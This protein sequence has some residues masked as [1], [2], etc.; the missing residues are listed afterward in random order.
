VTLQSTLYACKSSRV[1]LSE[2]INLSV[3]QQVH[4]PSDVRLHTKFIECSLLGAMPLTLLLGIIGWSILYKINTILLCW[5]KDFFFVNN[6]FHSKYSLGI[7]SCLGTGLSIFSRKTILVLFKF[8][9]CKYV[10]DCLFDK[11]IEKLE[12]VFASQTIELLIAKQ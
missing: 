3:T 7:S 8:I 9:F 4:A 5:L 10:L 12:L 6:L 2:T 1:C 11:E